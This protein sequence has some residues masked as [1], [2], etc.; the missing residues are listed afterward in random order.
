MKHH[1]LQ[2]VPLAKLRRWLAQAELAFGPT[3]STARVYRAEIRR[4][5]QV[6]R[7]KPGK[8]VLHDR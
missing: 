1:T 2:T 6:D 4:R 7:Q 3:C 5:L 8:A